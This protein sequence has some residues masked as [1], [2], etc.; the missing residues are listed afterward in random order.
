MVRIVGVS[1]HTSNKFIY[2]FEAINGKLAWKF[3]TLGKVDASPVIA[4]NLVVA[5]SCDGRLH[6]LDINTGNEI[7]TYEIGSAIFSTPAVTSKMIV[8]GAQD[9]KVYVF[10]PQDLILP[11][12]SPMEEGEDGLTITKSI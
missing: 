9:G 8:V 6:I 7:W 2:C 3:K 11:T 1:Q 12:P 10:G 5:A 4:G